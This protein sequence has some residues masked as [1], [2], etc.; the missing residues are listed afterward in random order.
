MNL[1][2][3]K[4]APCMTL[5]PADQARCTPAQQRRQRN[6][7]IFLTS[8]PLAL[9]V[10]ASVTKPDNDP[11]RGQKRGGHDSVATIPPQ[12]PPRPCKADTAGTSPARDRPEG[13]QT[14]RH[15]S[16]E[17][18]AEWLTRTL[19]E[20]GIAGGDVAKALDVT[21]SAISRWKNGKVRPELEK[22]MRLAAF[23]SVDPIRLAVTAGHMDANVVN[24]KPYP[25]PEVKRDLVRERLVKG[26]KDIQGL[27]ADDVE[28]ILATFDERSF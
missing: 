9:M 26:L 22:T 2:H 14:V 24:V 15:D 11:A 25:L 3:G 6:V 10:E 20:R 16:K 19:M 13:R 23:L 28:K 17:Y 7:R 27:G 1:V 4:L 21:D 12:H 8:G 18:F 5:K